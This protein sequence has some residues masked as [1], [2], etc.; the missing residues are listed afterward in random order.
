MI[1]IDTNIVITY[2]YENDNS[3]DEYVNNQMIIVPYF[4]KIE[5]INVLRKAHFF[6]ATPMDKINSCYENFEHIIDD[7]VDDQ[8]MFPVA[9]K[10]S[11]ELNHPIYDCLYLAV[12]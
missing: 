5:V 10:I 7:F 2:V 3:L 12:C 6:H 4:Q 8:L 11:I 1:T 9:R